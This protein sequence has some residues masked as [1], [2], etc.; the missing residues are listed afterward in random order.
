MQCYTAP[1]Q[2]DQS[3]E[4]IINQYFMQGA[5]TDAKLVACCKNC[6]GMKFCL[7]ITKCLNCTP[8][9]TILPP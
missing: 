5:S 8:T 2:W 7:T 9:L 4:K 3:R 6:T 1:S